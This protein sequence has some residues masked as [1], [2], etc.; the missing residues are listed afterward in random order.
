MSGG[1]RIFDKKLKLMSVKLSGP[2]LGG[3]PHV[4]CVL[5]NELDVPPADRYENTYLYLTICPFTGKGFAT[6]LFKTDNK[7]FG[8]FIQKAEENIEQNAAARAVTFYWRRSQST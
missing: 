7:S 1:R 5:A 8:W 4:S 3:Q 2:L 6:F